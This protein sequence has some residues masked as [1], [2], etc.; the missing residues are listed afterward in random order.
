MLGS[1]INRSWRGSKARSLQV[2]I[3]GTLTRPQMDQRAIAGLSQQLLQGAAQ[4]AI[5]GELNKATR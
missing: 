1:A 2:P 4:K 5:G 3:T